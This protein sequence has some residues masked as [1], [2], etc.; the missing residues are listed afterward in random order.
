[1]VT[2]Y[3]TGPITRAGSPWLWWTLVEV[4]V[5]VMK[6]PDHAGRWARRMAVRKGIHRARVAL[7]RRLCDAIIL[8]WCAVA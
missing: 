1:V 6:R 4:A 3:H 8:I 5:H 2:G 7:A